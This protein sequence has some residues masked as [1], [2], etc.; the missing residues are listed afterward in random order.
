MGGPQ[1]KAEHQFHPE[2]KWRFDFAHLPT[3]T[4]IEIEG[5]VLSGRSRHT[6]PTGFIKDCE[7]YNAATRAGWAIFRLPGPLIRPDALS[8]IIET[9]RN[10]PLCPPKPTADSDP[11]P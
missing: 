8:L 9:I 11:L 7:K 4:A 10:R 3:L 2:R 5:G 1:L 6:K